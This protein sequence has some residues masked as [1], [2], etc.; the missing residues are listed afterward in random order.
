VWSFVSILLSRGVADEMSAL[1]LGECYGW[2]HS[3]QEVQKIELK[4]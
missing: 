2:L 4:G 1:P 3:L